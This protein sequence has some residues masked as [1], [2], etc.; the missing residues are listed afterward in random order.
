V[1]DRARLGR[2]ANHDLPD[3]ALFE[4]PGDHHRAAAG[5]QH[6]L[7]TAIQADRELPDR[8]RCA[9]DPTDPRDP[10]TLSDRDLTEIEVNIQTKEPH[11]KPPSF[12][13]STYE[14]E[15]TAGSDNYGYGLSAHPGESQGRPSSH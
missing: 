6:H 3:V 9:R 12:T 15:G 8:L 11:E 13:N 14:M 5:L 2:I 7:V 1:R 10:A 4:E